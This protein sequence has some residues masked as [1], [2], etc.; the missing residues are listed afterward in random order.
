[1]VR[2]GND[3]AVV[4]DGNI[5]C[6]HLMSVE[7]NGNTDMVAMASGMKKTEVLKSN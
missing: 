6:R 7:I 5:Q 1:M 3:D 4:A 2:M